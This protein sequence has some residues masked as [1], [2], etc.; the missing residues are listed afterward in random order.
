MEQPTEAEL[1]YVC[2]HLEKLHQILT[3]VGENLGMPVETDE[4]ILHVAEK[5][6][7]GTEHLKPCG[8]RVSKC[9]ECGYYDG[10]VTVNDTVHKGEGDC[11]RSTLQCRDTDLACPDFVGR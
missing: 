1:Q 2:G 8:W 4:E 5:M 6:V 10:T 11:R 9:G 3:N 7:V